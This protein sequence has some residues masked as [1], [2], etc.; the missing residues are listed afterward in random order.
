MNANRN[1]ISVAAALLVGAAAC[2]FAAGSADAGSG[3]LS[4]SVRPGKA[5]TT[6]KWFGI[7]PM[8]M[9]PQLAAWIETEEGRYVATIAVTEKA[10][11]RSWTA[12]PSGG[13]PESLPIWY[14]AGGAAAGDVDAASSATPKGPV[15]LGAGAGALEPGKAYVVK[16]EVNKS[17][18]YNEAWPKDAKAGEGDPSG[19]NG[20]PSVLYEARFVAGSAGSVRLEPVGR[21]AVDGSSGEVKAG[22]EGLTTA[23]EIVDSAA[24]TIR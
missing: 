24:L 23:L 18:D 16:L 10:A 6:V 4:L 22:L 1:R 21:G 14:H 12:A 7:F 19:V 13:R 8:R 2:A 15:D 9:R 11:K 3:G 17:F 20:Q 5:W